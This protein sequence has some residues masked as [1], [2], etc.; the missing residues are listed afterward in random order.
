MSKYQSVDES[1]KWT[2]NL[3]RRKLY[4][5]SE[6]DERKYAAMLNVYAEKLESKLT[7]EID[8]NN[9]LINKLPWTLNNPGTA[10]SVNLAVYARET[11]EELNM[12]KSLVGSMEFDSVVSANH[13]RGKSFLEDVSRDFKRKKKSNDTKIQQTHN[14][15]NR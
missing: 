8:I 3:I 6:S 12:P 10:E 1:V 2:V 15:N 7:R 14:R 4:G 13:F 9:K 5:S 11:L